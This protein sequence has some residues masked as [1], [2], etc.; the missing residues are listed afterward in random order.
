MWE[1]TLHCNPRTGF[2]TAGRSWYQTHV[3]KKGTG[4]WFWQDAKGQMLNML[5]TGALQMPPANRGSTCDLNPCSAFSSLSARSPA[6]VKTSCLL[7]T[8]L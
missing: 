3:E 1:L 7:L 6:Y 8:S 5:T 2:F 4:P